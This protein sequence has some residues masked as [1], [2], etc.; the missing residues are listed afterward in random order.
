VD[1]GAGMSITGDRSLFT[2][3]SVPRTPCPSFGDGVVQRGGY[4]IH[5][6][7]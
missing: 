6:V 5:S 3:F 7:M 1:S 4:G 2:V